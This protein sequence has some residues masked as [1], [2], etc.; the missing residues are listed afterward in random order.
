[1]K[2]VQCLQDWSFDRIR[3]YA[4]AFRE[5]VIYTDVDDV[6]AAEMERAGAGR[7]LNEMTAATFAARQAEKLGG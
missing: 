2:S 4:R 5:G 1:M 3:R 6:T 7:V